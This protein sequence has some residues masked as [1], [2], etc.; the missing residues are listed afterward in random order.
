VS[1]AIAIFLVGVVAAST[2]QVLMKKGAMLGAHQAVARSFFNLYTLGGYALMLS[3]TVTSTIALKL[4][5]LKLTV[6]LLPVGYILVAVWS[7]LALGERLSRTQ[8]WGMVV[9][10]AGILLFS[11][12]V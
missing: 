7:S 1:G 5:P 11:R 2:G 8:R 3:S 9:V 6:S 12:G 10:I 4:M